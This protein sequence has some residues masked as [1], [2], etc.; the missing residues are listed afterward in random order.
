MNVG[1][2]ERVH[3]WPAWEVGHWMG[4]GRC[5]VTKLNQTMNAHVRS[6]SE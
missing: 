2:R 6:S 5:A 1:A 4:A 3:D